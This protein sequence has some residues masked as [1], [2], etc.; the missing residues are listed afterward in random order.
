MAD[1]LTVNLK[2]L[3]DWTLNEAEDLSTI[4]DSSQ[5]KYEKVF[6]DGISDNQVNHIW[7]F[8]H[9]L[10]GSGTKTHDLTALDTQTVFGGSHVAS[11]Q[12]VKIIVIQNTNT[13]AGDDLY[14]DAGASNAFITMF[15]GSTTA[16]VEIPSDS[17]SVFSNRMTG[18]AVTGGTGDIISITNDSANE[19]TYNI[20]VAGIH[21]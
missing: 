1:T 4:S 13:T 3:F 2:A 7:H 17:I 20:V 14:L 19:V 9:A 6:E 16:K 5:I 8:Q 15:N 18:W 12:K 10:A 21:S 11:F